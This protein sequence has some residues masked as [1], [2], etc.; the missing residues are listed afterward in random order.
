[1]AALLSAAIVP[2][3][4]QA[5][6]FDALLKDYGFSGNP[7]QDAPLY[8]AAREAV[9]NHGGKFM[10]VD[11]GKD[12]KTGEARALRDF[13]ADVANIVATRYE[14]QPEL[15]AD[16]SRLVQVLLT[17]DCDAKLFSQKFDSIKDASD[18]MLAQA[19]P[20]NKPAPAPRMIMGK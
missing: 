7:V 20:Q 1:M 18:Y 12:P 14:K 13:A 11:F 5:K 10:D 9:V 3:G 16:V 15:A 8:R 2:A 4:P 6:A 17:G 19:K